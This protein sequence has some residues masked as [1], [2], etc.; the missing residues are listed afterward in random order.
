MT[1]SFPELIKHAAQTRKLSA[2]SIIGSGTISNKNRRSGS[3]CI[4][5]QRMLE[6]IKYGTPKTEFLQEGDCVRL[7]ML[8]ENDT[9]IFGAINQNVK[10]F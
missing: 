6:I 1:F 10:N 5:E 9:S 8:D 3:A 4:A 7:E 2:G